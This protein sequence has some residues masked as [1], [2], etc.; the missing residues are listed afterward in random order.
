MFLE[1][2]HGNCNTAH[3][4]LLRLYIGNVGEKKLSPN[5]VSE[6]CSCP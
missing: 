6:L 2:F 1:K 4:S 5:I 3:S